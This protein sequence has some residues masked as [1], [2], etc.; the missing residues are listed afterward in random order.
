MLYSVVK[1]II[2]GLLHKDV[3][4]DTLNAHKARL[5]DINESADGPSKK[6][7]T[8]CSFMTTITKFC[9]GEINTAIA[10]QNLVFAKASKKETGPFQNYKAI[11]SKIHQAV[12][13]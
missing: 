13:T 11:L 3:I 9:Q 5:L 2:L 7:L 10:E 6:L 12:C 4:G 1:Q 8:P